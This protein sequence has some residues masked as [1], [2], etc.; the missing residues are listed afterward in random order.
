MVEKREHLVV[1]LL[2]TSWQYAKGK[3]KIKINMLAYLAT[4]PKSFHPI[5]NVTNA[6]TCDL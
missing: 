6:L 1:I 3:C 2:L 4:L 5:A